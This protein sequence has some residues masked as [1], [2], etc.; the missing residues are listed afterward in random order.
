MLPAS[1][2]DVYVTPVT[3]SVLTV[4][5]TTDEVV[6]PRTSPYTVPNSSLA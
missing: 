4:G 5:A 2:A 6:K 1:V 3:A